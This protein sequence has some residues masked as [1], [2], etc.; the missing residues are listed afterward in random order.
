MSQ[1]IILVVIGIGW[2]I[3]KIFEGVSST[4]SAISENS[5]LQAERSKKFG[6]RNI[7]LNKTL[8]DR[9]IDV[10]EKFAD[11]IEPDGYRSY[12][13][14]NLVRD[15]LNEICLAENTNSL[16]PGY[17]YLSTWKSRASEEWKQLAAQIEKY[18]AEKKRQLKELQ[19][20]I[21]TSNNRLKKAVSLNVDPL[22]YRKVDKRPSDGGLYLEDI[23]TVLT[24][25]AQTWS[26]KEDL[27]IQG[28]FR[29]EKFPSF[30]SEPGNPAVAKLN[31]EIDKFNEE[32]EKQQS[33]HEDNAQFFKNIFDGF[34]LGAVKEVLNRIDYIIN[35][36]ELPNSFPKIWDADYDPEQGIA[37]VEISLPDIVHNEVLKT[38]QLKSKTSE[39]PL[40]QKEKREYLPKVHPA[41]IL[42]VG[43]ELLRNDGPETIKLLVL[44]GWVEYDDPATGSR[45]KTYTA[46]LTITHDQAVGLNL[47]K[48]DSL[49]AFL[50]L[51]GKTAGA[52][53]DIIPVTPTLSLNKKDKRFIATKEV[54]NKLGN[55]TNLAS[56]DWQDFESLIA[57]LFQKEFAEKGAEVKVTQASRDRGVD[58]VVFD[59]D[60]IKGGKFI[61]QAKRYTNT[62]DVS[63]VRDLCAVVKK[64]GAS[65]GILVTTS[66]YGAD[67]Y[68][69]AQNEPITLLNGSE[70]LGLLEKHGY[71]FKI[72]LVEARKL[73]K[74]T[75]VL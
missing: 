60:P 53:I 22:T 9:N 64:E 52:L 19:E 2:V 43:F 70:L 66:S 32:L 25:N 40:S 4:G 35:D 12:Y 10:I 65:R 21:S 42:R 3:F 59:P 7:D 58:A 44:N 27:L 30:D 49:A 14:E 46:S 5:K 20:K 16:K 41:V 68:T 1:I 61:I 50:N 26:E 29:T 56:M 73:L 72:N 51:K 55:E 67:A 18:F 8:F 38:V 48:L 13:L 17:D 75:S 31:A 47:S 15:C 24:P 57:E 33:I 74:E 69:F 62:V 11:T 6:N 23:Q 71:K 45:T 37:I 39:K 36:I 54:L 63:A 34:D 28:K